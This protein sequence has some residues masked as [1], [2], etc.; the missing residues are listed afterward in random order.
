VHFRTLSIPDLEPGS[1]CHHGNL[2]I[3]ETRLQGT[4]MRTF[5]GLPPTGRRIDMPLVAIFV[6][7]GPDLLCERVYWDRLT[8]FIQLGVA[9]DPN[10]PTG[11]LMTLL[12]HPVMLTRAALRSRRTA[13]MCAGSAGPTTGPAPRRRARRRTP[14]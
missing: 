1:L 11:K 4:H 2:V 3:G 8:L 5:R 10:T 9:R 13:R 7:D 12:N 14:R 6:F